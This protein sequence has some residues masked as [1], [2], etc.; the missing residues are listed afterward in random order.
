MSAGGGQR[1]VL[2]FDFGGTLDADGI[3]WKDRFYDVWRE[4]VGDGP[5]ERFDRAFYAADD[6]LVGA[7]PADLPLTETIRRLACGIGREL[8]AGGAAAERAGSR[9]AS[10]SL[11]TLARRAPLLAR[12]AS[13]YRLGIVSNFYGNLAAAC[14][15]AGIG[16]YFVAT[17]DSVDVGCVKPDARIFHAALE[18]LNASPA[19]AVFV[20][21]SPV[22]DMAGARAI[23]MRHVLL[24]PASGKRLSLC[25]SGDR[26]IQTLEQLPKALA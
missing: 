12:L 11:H 17:I 24:R 10:E 3:A 18:R 22:R 5:R 13:R 9:F 20:G 2:L 8:A 7:I 25:C 19:E 14:E 21:D 16:R 15:E 4:E 1:G 6:A 26:E 23:G